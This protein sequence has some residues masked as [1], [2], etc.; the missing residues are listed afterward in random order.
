MTRVPHLMDRAVAV[1]LFMAACNAAAVLVAYY[2]G[3]M[4]TD[5][6]N[7]QFPLGVDG[8][9]IQSV[10]F[11]FSALQVYVTLLFRSV[12]GLFTQSSSGRRLLLLKADAEYVLEPGEAL[13]PSIEVRGGGEGANNLA[14]TPEGKL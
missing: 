1:G 8:L 13:A 6:V 12:V 5:V 2:A 7:R 14:T 11:A 3:L 9:E 10:Q 4:G